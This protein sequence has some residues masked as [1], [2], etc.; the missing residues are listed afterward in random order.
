[1]LGGQASEAYGRQ[2]MKEGAKADQQKRCEIMLQMAKSTKME[3]VWWGEMRF[4]KKLT[5]LCKKE[6]SHRAVVTITDSGGNR[7]LDL[8]PISA[9]DQLCDLSELLT[10]SFL[11]YT[12]R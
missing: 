11:F 4:N 2:D 5:V 1:M 3:V 12:A 10:L 9:T 6:T 8:N 7:F